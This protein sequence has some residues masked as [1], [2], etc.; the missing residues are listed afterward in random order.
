M[1]YPTQLYLLIALVGLVSGALPG[2]VFPE[3]TLLTGDAR[4]EVPVENVYY[5]WIDSDG[6]VQYTDFEPIGVSSQRVELKPEEEAVQNQ[7]MLRSADNDRQSDSFHDQDDQI[8]PI[9]HIGP[10]ANARQQLTVLHSEL[11]VYVSEQGNYRTAWRGDAYRGERVFLVEEERQAAIDTARAAVLGNCSD[12]AA[13][14]E[15]VDAFRKSV[16]NPGR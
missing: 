9:E 14:E 10:C 4:Q 13:F 2:V 5:R 12:P 11:P 15:E 3:E 16:G 7:M 1:K 6:R 8:L